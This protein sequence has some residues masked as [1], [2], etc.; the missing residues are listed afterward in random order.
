MNSHT[1]IS[2]VLVDNH[3]LVLEGLRAIL[4]TYDHIRVVGTAAAVPRGLEIS[5]AQMP[6]IVLLDINM[7]QISGIDAIELFKNVAPSTKILMLSMHDSREYIS[8]S[9]VRGASGYILKDVPNEEIV[10]AIETVAAGGSYFS[11][12]VSD[13]LMQR[14]QRGDQDPLPITAREREILA[15]LAAGRSN[16]DIAQSLRI[17][18][19]TAETHRKK[20][21][22]KLG[23]ATT[24]GLVRFAIDNGLASPEADIPTTG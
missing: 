12:G 14:R 3:P 21:K 7:P 20:I 23:I 5:A 4:E 11:T 15:L 19:A 13:V 17:S 8:A 18:E 10:E 24:A 16:R 1:P 22:K 2:I 9:V 6:D